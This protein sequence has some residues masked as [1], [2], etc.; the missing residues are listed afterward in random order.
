[1]TP[2][3]LI[4]S[5]LH[6]FSADLVA[7][8]LE[9]SGV[10]Y[11]RVNREHLA[12]QRLALDPLLPSLTIRG[13][14]RTYSINS[15]LKAIWF[16]QPVFLRNTP[17]V[18]LSLDE[19]LARSQW[20]A[21]LRSLCVFRDVAWMNFPGATYLAESKPYQLA[22]A[23]RCGFRVP[24]TIATNDVA[25]IQE[26]SRT[27]LVIKSLD[28]VLLRDGK[29][30]L[31][32]Y[33]T[34]NPGNKLRDETVCA[35]PLLAQ[36]H[37]SDKTDIRVTVVG[38]KVFAVRILS[39]GSSIGGDW[40]TLP[41]KDIQYHDLALDDDLADRCR[42]LTRT[43]NLS[44]GAIDLIETPSGIY[45]IEINPTGEWGWLS[46]PERPIDKAI[47]SWLQTPE[48]KDATP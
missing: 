8:Q 1:M 4:L 47:A 16:R 18:P 38:D 14:S 44:F 33:T 43:L 7:V 22:V 32:T 27:D 31:F 35:A 34:V 23:H 26:I 17:S 30:C 3:I 39:H 15:H 6:D 37:L 48:A 46:S 40:R 11:V 10:P 24:A 45:F 5:S 42:L 13:S 9:R 28:T 12:E 2:N 21:F 20:T 36:E 25:R 41:R 29:D 19:Q